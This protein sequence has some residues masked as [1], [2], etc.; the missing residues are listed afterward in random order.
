MSYS[1]PQR[2]RQ[3]RREAG[4]SQERLAQL[5]GVSHRQMQR[6][7]YGD[8]PDIGVGMLERI[9]LATGKPLTWF[10]AREIVA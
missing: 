7:E 9:A 10:V 2:I 4:L 1:L 8:A 3:A 5:I 6:M